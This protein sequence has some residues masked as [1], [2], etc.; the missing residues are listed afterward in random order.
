MHGGTYFM[1]PAIHCREAA[2]AQVTHNDV[3]TDLEILDALPIRSFCSRA[4][5]AS[6]G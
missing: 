4:W 3:G 2:L 1:I 5:G 6:G